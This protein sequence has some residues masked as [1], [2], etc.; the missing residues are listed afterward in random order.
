MV[1]QNKNWRRGIFGYIEANCLKIQ[2]T[3]VTQ[4]AS[5]NLG[6]PKRRKSSVNVSEWDPKV[7]MMDVKVVIVVLLQKW[8]EKKWI[9]LQMHL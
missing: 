3:S 5:K 8:Q 9:Q 7:G 4:K 2:L 6:I 1:K